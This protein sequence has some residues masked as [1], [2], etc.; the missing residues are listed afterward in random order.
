MHRGS[1]S[2]YVTVSG[3][4]ARNLEDKAIKKF[5]AGI[6][7]QTDRQ[8]DRQTQTD[9]DI[10][11]HTDKYNDTKTDR[12]THIDRQ[13]YRHRQTQTDR[14]TEILPTSPDCTKAASAAT[15]LLVV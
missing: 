8:T 1:F 5:K 11:T 9:T 3:M 10:Q 12:K 7:T 4:I 15:S 6:R 13:T 2:N 14:H